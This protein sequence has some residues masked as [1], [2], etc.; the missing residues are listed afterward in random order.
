MA[1]EEWL[2]ADLLVHL[3]LGQHGDVVGA[4]KCGSRVAVTSFR[5][6]HLLLLSVQRVLSQPRVVLHDFQA[7]GRVSLV[8]GSRIVVLAVLR[9]NNT[10]DLSGFGLLCHVVLLC[11]REAGQFS[12]TA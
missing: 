11:R 2:A 10:D 4:T 12:G 1:Q 6:W 9:A 5:V 7:L 3:N 8:L